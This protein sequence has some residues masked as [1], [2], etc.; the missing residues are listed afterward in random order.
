[1]AKYMREM[2]RTRL[3]LAQE[4]HTNNFIFLI[5]LSLDADGLVYGPRNAESFF[6]AGNTNRFGFGRL[7]WG[8]T[9]GGIKRVIVAC[10]RAHETRGK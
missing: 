3:A 10:A 1:M 7:I 8:R 4:E 9:E 5:R 6:L 2:G